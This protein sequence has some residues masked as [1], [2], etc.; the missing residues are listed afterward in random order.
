[1]SHFFSS[2]ILWFYLDCTESDL[3]GILCSTVSTSHVLHL[4]QL[5]WCCHIQILSIFPI[6]PTRSSY[7]FYQHLM[8]LSN[9]SYVLSFHCSVV[10]IS[11]RCLLFFASQ[12]LIR[13]V[14]AVRS[15][16]FYVFL[17]ILVVNHM[18][19]C[20]S[21]FWRWFVVKNVF[22]TQLCVGFDVHTCK[23][24]YKLPGCCIVLMSKNVLKVPCNWTGLQLLMYGV[25]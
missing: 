15:V 9:L 7:F 22:L 5:E 6:F 12:T 24:G 10:Q 17:K 19:D 1:M 13:I 14:R 2:S 25:K 11:Y 16:G 23:W 8:K 4:G 3:H 20:S 21:I 18:V